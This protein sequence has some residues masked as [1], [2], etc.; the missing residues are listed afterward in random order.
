MNSTSASIG[1][2]LLA[3]APLRG[4][5]WGTV[6]HVGARQAS[7]AVSARRLL[8][9]DGDPASCAQLRAA[10]RGRAAV[11]IREQVIASVDGLVA[12]HLHNWRAA[13]GL[14]DLSGALAEIY[15]RLRLLDRRQVEARS[16]AEVLEE[17]EIQRVGGRAEVN[18]LVLDVPSGAEAMLQS[19][20]PE[21]L[22]GFDWIVA[23]GLPDDGSGT[24]SPSYLRPQAWAGSPDRLAWRVWQVDHAARRT[25][26]ELA[27]TREE[28][29]AALLHLEESRHRAGELAQQLTQQAVHLEDREREWTA[30]LAKHVARLSV[31]D[32]E[33]VSRL[34]EIE[35][36]QQRLQAVTRAEGK[37][38]LIAELLLAERLQ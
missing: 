36:L 28:L 17:A 26:L 19:L 15:P 6:V 35:R 1:S 8:V 27:R 22:M 33:L 14:Q 23:G 37:L 24:T 18:A 34:G 12:W 38:D 29:D 4:Q 21:L 9:F 30:T 32:Q 13:D 3:L 16:L 2:P 20:A 11:S 10:T 25:S 31:Q 7:A 5:R